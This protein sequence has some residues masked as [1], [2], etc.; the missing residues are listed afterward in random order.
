MMIISVQSTPVSAESTITTKDLDDAYATGHMEGWNDR[1]D[2]TD[3]D[4]EDGYL[5]GVTDT[6]QDREEARATLYTICGESGGV[7]AEDE[8]CIRNP[9]QYYGGKLPATH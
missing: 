4:F 6:L 1:E 2:S 8:S 7:M 5:A 3:L 9:E